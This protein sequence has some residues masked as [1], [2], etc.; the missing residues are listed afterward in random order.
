MEAG[1]APNAYT[2]DA[3]YWQIVRAKS[4]RPYP[5]PVVIGRP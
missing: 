1:P 5:V 3:K 2:I 4:F